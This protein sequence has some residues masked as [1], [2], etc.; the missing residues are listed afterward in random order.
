MLFATIPFEIKGEAINDI[1]TLI[2]TN[3]TLKGYK[4]FFKFVDYKIATLKN[5]NINLSYI[6]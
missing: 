4:Q 1:W 6:W 3:V 2:V 5:I